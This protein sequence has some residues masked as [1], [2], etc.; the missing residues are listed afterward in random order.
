MRRIIGT[1]AVLVLAAG[2][3]CDPLTGPEG[4]LEWLGIVQGKHQEAIAGVAELDTPVVARLVRTEGGQ[5][6]LHVG[7]R[8]LYAQM[9]VKGVAGAV[10]CV[11]ETPVLGDGLT[12]HARCTN[13]DSDGKA[14]FHLTPSTK[15]G[16]HA[17]PIVAEYDGKA[18]TPDTVFATVHPGP[19][20]NDFETVIGLARSSQPRT[21][22]DHAGIAEDQY[23]N[24]VPSC[25]RFPPD[26]SATVS[27]AGVDWPECRTISWVDVAEGEDPLRGRMTAWDSAGV[28]IGHGAYEISYHAA[29]GS[30]G[31]W[32]YVYGM[33]RDCA[34]CEEWSLP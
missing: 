19:A 16:E 34:K 29:S 23:G 31:L 4:V 2:F 17:S 25:P 26:D 14:I 24:I 6:T 10:V 18:L 1:F 15:A 28:Q 21:M 9:T 30:G 12:P 20:V 3:A 22:P 11:G 27:I 7:P 33:A 8:P 13:T 32:M 5:V